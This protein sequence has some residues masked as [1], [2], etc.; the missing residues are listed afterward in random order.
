VATWSSPHRVGFAWMKDNTKLGDSELGIT[1]VRCR[2]RGGCVVAP[3]R[4]RRSDAES[5]QLLSAPVHQLF[6]ARNGIYLHENLI[7]GAGARQRLRS[8][9]SSLLRLKGATGSPETNR[10]PVTGC[11]HRGAPF[12]AT[13]PTSRRWFDAV[14]VRRGTPL[15]D[16]DRHAQELT[17]IPRRQFGPFCA[18]TSRQWEFGPA[19]Q[20]GQVHG[21]VK[22]GAFPD[23]ISLKLLS[24]DAKTLR[25]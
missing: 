24:G 21:L 2:R 5:R 10:D 8:V 17:R 15:N 23:D 20:A 19:R 6:L 4:G 3:T 12:L 13:G 11:G 9:C 22:S 16:D 18:S 25:A 7:T 1:A 14:L